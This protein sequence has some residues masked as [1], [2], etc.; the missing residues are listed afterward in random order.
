MFSWVSVWRCATR[1]VAWNLRCGKA[2][3]RIAIPRVRAPRYSLR[4]AIE[5]RGALPHAWAMRAFAVGSIVLLSVACSSA[6]SPPA[7]PSESAGADP[8]T[9]KDSESKPLPPLEAGEKALRASE[10]VEARK[11]FE[12]AAKVSATRGPALL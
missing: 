7:A 3:P 9:Q 5:A 4:C 11:H 10:F 8:K 2:A 12:L 6:A 1:G